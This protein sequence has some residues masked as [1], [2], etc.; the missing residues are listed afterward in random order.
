LIGKQKAQVAALAEAF[1][2]LSAA[3]FLLGA[4]ARVVY[5]NESARAALASGMPLVVKQGS[6]GTADGRAQSEFDKA[7]EATKRRDS[8]TGP[9]GSTLVLAATGDKRYI[10]HFLPLAEADLRNGKAPRQA[11]AAVFLT[12]ATME[13]RS[14]IETISRTYGLTPREASI[15]VALVEIGGTT[16]VAAQFGLSVSTVKT[17]V[18]AIFGKTSVVRQADL[19]KLVAGYVTPAVSSSVKPS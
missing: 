9:A 11:V 3:V 17:H 1:D 12:L 8:N 10:A 7:F 18:K 4:G 16:E 2:H 19:V 6:L 15:L 13:T 14:P 5:L